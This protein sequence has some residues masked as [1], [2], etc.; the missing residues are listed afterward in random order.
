LV[1]RRAGIEGRA[2]A[3]REARVGEAVGDAGAL[4]VR[5]ALAAD[6]R[7]GPSCA[8]AAVWQLAAH[9]GAAVEPEADLA[10]IVAT[11]AAIVAAVERATKRPSFVADTTPTSDG[12]ERRSAI[13]CVL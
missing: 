4:R 12:R 13:E 8:E 3:R 2:V 1:H 7:G 5:N 6:E 11:E 9:D 10:A